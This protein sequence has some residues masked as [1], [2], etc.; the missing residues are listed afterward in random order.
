MWKLNRGTPIVHSDS[1]S[2]GSRVHDPCAE[3]PDDEYEQTA[4]GLCKWVRLVTAADPNVQQR[5]EELYYSTW[6]FLDPE[7]V[8]PDL[9][10]LD[11][12]VGL[13]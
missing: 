1:E 9:D 12:G 5:Y 3:R 4:D 13:E 10:L 8:G 7:Y 6:V 2:V 11:R